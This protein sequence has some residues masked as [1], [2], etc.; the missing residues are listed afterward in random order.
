MIKHGDW[1]DTC[2]FNLA[3]DIFL[4]TETTEM[5]KLSPESNV[6]NLK[7]M[8]SLSVDFTGFYRTIAGWW[9]GTFFIFPNSWDDD[10]IWLIFFR[11]VETTNQIVFQSSST[12]AYLINLD[13]NGP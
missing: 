2:D 8:G 11:G 5:V 4:L 13:K 1:L 10:P 9:F 3:M 7:K 6:L 12:V